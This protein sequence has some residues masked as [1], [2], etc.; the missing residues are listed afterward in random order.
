MNEILVSTEAEADVD[1]TWLY[2]ARESRSADIANRVI[3]G[4][5]ATF[6]LLARHPA[7]GRIRD[8]IGP[9]IRSFASG[10][11]L[12]LY[13][14]RKPGVVLILHIAA[15]GRDIFALD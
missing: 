6:S 15:R 8:D 13:E 3:D 10:G 9:G 5:T 7:A 12:I 4:I 2:V 1:A 11:Y 14:H